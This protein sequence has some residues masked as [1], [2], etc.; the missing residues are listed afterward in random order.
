MSQQ[1][2][3]HYAVQITYYTMLTLCLF[4]VRRFNDVYDCFTSFELNSKMESR[5]R[6]YLTFKPLKLLL[7]YEL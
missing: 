7:Q 6:I 3:M 5:T 1:V 2:P 4:T